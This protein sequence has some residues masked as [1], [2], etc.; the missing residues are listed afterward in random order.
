M[1]RFRFIGYDLSPS[2]KRA[3]LCFFVSRKV[4]KKCEKKKVPAGK[5]RLFAFFQFSVIGYGLAL[6]GLYP[7]VG[8]AVVP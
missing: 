3:P 8:G 5:I 6:H 1:I 4:R 2:S 7:D